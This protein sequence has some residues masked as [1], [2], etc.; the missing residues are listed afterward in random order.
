MKSITKEIVVFF[1][2]GTLNG[3]AGAYAAWQIYRDRLIN[4]Q[5]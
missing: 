5:Q 3:K 2:E 1:H 4:A